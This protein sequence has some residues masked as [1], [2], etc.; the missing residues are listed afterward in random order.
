[1]VENLENADLQKEIN[2][3]SLIFL[4]NINSNC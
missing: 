4:W 3:E 2:L 1:M